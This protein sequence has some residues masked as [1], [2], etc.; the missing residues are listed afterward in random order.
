LDRR[1]RNR[2]VGAKHAAIAREGLQSLPAA[3]AVVEE[4]AGVGGHGLNGLMAAL[5]A[6]KRRFQLHERLVT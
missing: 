4:L 2:T 3:L 6:G 1:T 5:R